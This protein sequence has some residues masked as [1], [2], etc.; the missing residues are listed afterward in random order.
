MAALLAATGLPPVDFPNPL[1]A[2][3]VVCPFCGGTRAVYYA[4]LGQWGLSWTYNPLGLLLLA[5]AA[6]TTVRHMAGAISGRWL[7]LH[8]R[9]HRATIVVISALLAVGVLA[10][11]VN[12]QLHAELLLTG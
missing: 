5:G 3:G 12:Q 7:N 4:M 11:W 8:V 2:A 6:A 9:R 10:L 1:H